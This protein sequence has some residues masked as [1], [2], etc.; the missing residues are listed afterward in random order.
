LQFTISR[1]VVLIIA[2]AIFCAFYRRST[3][4]YSGALSIGF[5]LTTGLF[6]KRPVA[7]M[8]LFGCIVVGLIAICYVLIGV[9][10]E[11]FVQAS[12]SGKIDGLDG[13]V[14][15]LVQSALGLLMGATFGL[16]VYLILQVAKRYIGRRPVRPVPDYSCGPI[17]WRR[18]DDTRDPASDL[19]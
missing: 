12:F 5:Y 18:L 6:G 15:W 1:L 2:I 19:R 14:I 17:V 7:H 8:G 16:A 9:V 13:D 3:L 10:N 11:N 4:P